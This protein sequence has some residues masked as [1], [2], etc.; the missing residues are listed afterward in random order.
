MGQAAAA[1]P[2][3]EPGACSR[4]MGQPAAPRRLARPVRRYMGAELLA[5]ARAM[6]STPDPDDG[7]N[8]NKETPKKLTP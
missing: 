4:S 5:K 8:N 2:A 3:D 1:G 7:N 6:A